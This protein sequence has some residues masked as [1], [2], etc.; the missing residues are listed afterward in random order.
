[1]LIEQ[2]DFHFERLNKVRDF[3]IFSCYTGLAF[4]DI[5]TL[6]Y[7]N[8]KEGIDGNLWIFK[9]RNKTKV[10][11][12]IPLLSVPL[13]LIEKYRNNPNKKDENLV[14]PMSTNQKMNAYLKE[15]ADICGID[16]KISTHTGRHT[17]ATT[18][19]LGSGSSFEA[20]SKMLGHSDINM[21]KIYARLTEKLVSDS[22]NKMRLANE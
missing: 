17:F 6:T 11:S 18:I 3:F 5:K 15:I 12:Y 21:T 2:K 22:F 1:M 7:Q 9:K 19:A 14:F 13:Q 20:T 16:K 8:L 4:S 10:L